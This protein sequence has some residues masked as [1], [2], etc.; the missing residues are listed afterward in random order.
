MSTIFNGLHIGYSGLKTSQLAIDVTGHNV[1]NADNESYTRQRAVITSK[2][3]LNVVGGDIGLG[4]K[5]DKIVRI[6]DEFV[7]NRL[8]E[9]NTNL[10]YYSYQEEVLSE[11]SAFFP[12]IEENGIYNDF[13][14]YMNAWND[15][16]KNTDDAALKINLAEQSATL[17]QSIQTTRQSVYEVQVGLDDQL[18]AAIDEINRLGSEIAD[19]NERIAIN[20]AGGVSQAND[21]RDERD[22]RELAL[23]KLIDI[24]VSKSNLSSD[25]VVDTAIYDGSDSYN[26]SVGGVSLVDGSTFHS[27][28]YEKVESG[29]R[30]GSI[31]SER[32]DG[33]LIDISD[34][35]KGGEAGAILDLRGSNYDAQ[36][37]AFTD[38]T[39]QNLVDQLDTFAKGLIENTNNLYAMHATTSM[40][41]D[42]SI[43]PDQLV[44]Q[45]NL[46]INTSGRAF[47]V[48]IFDLDGNT[49]A[50]REIML[51][52]T[53]TYQD[54]V[55]AI[56][57]NTLDDNSDNATG[58]DVD[59]FVAATLATDS[60]GDTYFSLAMNDQAISDGYYFNIEEAD[61]SAPTGFAG[62]LGLE[63]FF[64]GTDASNIALNREFEENPT[65]IGGNRTPISGENDLA[66]AIL[67]LQYEKVDF[68]QNGKVVATDTLAGY[69]KMS[70]TDLSGTTASII[71]GFETADSLNSAV[72]SEFDSITKVDVDEEMTNLIKFQASYAASAKVISTI[73]QMIETLL[74]IKQ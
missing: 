6:H 50:S 10:R 67:Q 34:Y 37:G 74:T 66:N 16:S 21:L 61:S 40:Y 1:A 46:G 2:D 42:V 15:F 25:I 47:V 73:D 44:S 3:A 5:I 68:Y 33:R 39:L 57:D 70:V 26:L 29:S 19:I 52:G 63:R 71:S 62:A 53:M 49:I 8:K 72:K 9:S 35:V 65:T 64:D 38:G 18:V 27:I 41:S 58:N 43:L 30:F 48:N 54:V 22:E 17:A 55:A 36:K 14:N 32:Q 60:Q 24:T 56:N 23:A 69:F 51:D 4:S 59:D 12:E 11:V 45:Q 7:F 13:Q 28:Q 20:E 31:Y